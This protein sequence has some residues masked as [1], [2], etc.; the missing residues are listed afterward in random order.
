MRIISLV[1]SLTELLFGLG[2]EEE[3]IGRTRFCYHPETK[4]GNVQTLGGTK[5]PKIEEI[6]RLK[7]DLVIANKEENR[8]EDIDALQEKVPVLLTEI[9]TVEDAFLAIHDIGK[10]TGKEA[11]AFK[12]IEKC[13]QELENVEFEY[14]LRVAYLIWRNPWMVAARNTYIDD[15]LSKWGLNNVFADQKRYPEIGLDDLKKKY[16]DLILLSSEPYPFKEKHI[17]E[18]REHLPAARIQLVDGE[19]FSWYGSRMLPSFKALNHWR[20]EL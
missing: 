6:L 12:F 19:W 15:V 5:N 20:S 11:E 2:L 3:I 4:V 14:P 7:P 8:K 13:Q 17:E 9:D 1:P 10:T 18:I 16:P